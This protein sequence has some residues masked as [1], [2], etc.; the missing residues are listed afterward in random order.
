[1]LPL[2][3]GASQASEVHRDRVPGAPLPP[4][5]GR[6]GALTPPRRERSGPARPAG[7][8]CS[9]G[10]PVSTPHPR[11]CS[12][13]SHYFGPFCFLLKLFFSPGLVEGARETAGSLGFGHEGRL[14]FQD[15]RSK[16]RVSQ[17]PAPLPPLLLTWAPL[18]SG[19]WETGAESRACFAPTLSGYSL[20]LRPKS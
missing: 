19:R 12:P 4:L 2:R 7:S 3:S 13:G 20:L 6:D 8:S 15:N 16:P 9:P 1:M 5:T 10:L 14:V 11:R 18:T 17:P